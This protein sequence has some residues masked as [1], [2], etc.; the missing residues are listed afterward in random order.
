MQSLK[1]YF[2]ICCLLFFCSIILAQENEY[3]TPADSIYQFGMEAHMN[4]D[5]DLANNCFLYLLDATDYF[6]KTKNYNSAIEYAVCN[7][8]LSSI[9]YGENSHEHVYA[10]IKCANIYDGLGRYG[11][12]I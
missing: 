1:S 9:N 8:K 2:L 4:D 7:Q 11:E 6:L 10:L 5:R 3:W 12:A